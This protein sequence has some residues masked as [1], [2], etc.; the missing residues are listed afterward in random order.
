MTDPSAHASP[1]TFL[2]VP[3]EIRRKIYEF[4]FEG[5]TVF[6]KPGKRITRTIKITRSPEALYQLLLT[7]RLCHN[8]ARPFFYSSTIWVID[9]QYTFDHFVLSTRSTGD[10]CSVKYVHIALVADLAQLRYELLPSL[11]ILTFE[12]VGCCCDVCYDGGSNPRLEWA[13]GESSK[14]S[15]DK[16][17]AYAKGLRLSWISRAASSTIGEWQTR[18]KPF[19]TQLNLIVVPDNHIY[20]HDYLV[21]CLRRVPNPCDCSSY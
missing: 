10:S 12:H 17:I 18:P 13:D 5:N 14:V 8:E 7:C 9:D 20:H 11:K 16:I 3:A 4:V 1:C 21:G 2:S 19:Q 6:V 15:D